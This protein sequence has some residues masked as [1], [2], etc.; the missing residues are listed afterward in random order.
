MFEKQDYLQYLDQLHKVELRMKNG[1][2]VLLEEN[3]DRHSQIILG[4]ILYDEH[5]HMQMLGE[6]IELVL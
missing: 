1:T 2:E 6:I 3:N 5:E 4:K